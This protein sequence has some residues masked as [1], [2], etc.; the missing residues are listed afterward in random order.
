MRF[1]KDAVRPVDCCVLNL[2]PAKEPVVTREGYIF[3]R[4]AVIE[5]M[6]HEK[7]AIA[8]RVKQWKKRRDQLAN[9]KK[10]VEESE[11][12]AQMAKFAAAERHVVS[13]STA[14]S[15]KVTSNATVSA[16]ANSFWV[17]GV[18]KTAEMDSLKDLPPR[19]DETVR[20][21]VTNKPLKLKDLIPVKFKLAKRDGTET[22]ASNVQS[23]EN[24]SYVCAL[25]G[26]IL[27]NSQQLAVLL[28]SSAVVLQSAADQILKYDSKHSEKVM[29][30]IAN[31][32]L[33][34]IISLKRGGS[35]FTAAVGE[36]L[37]Q[38][39]ATLKKPA[40]AIN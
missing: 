2:Q 3:D 14:S 24:G 22:S 16:N 1:S 13:S 36:D 7:Q 11:K 4:S 20:C 38:I 19:P 25:T 37:T 8:L 27:T 5:Y 26:D 39:E 29:D 32:E 6:V 21:P 34:D 12:N 35:G 15:S 23:I 18:S 40:L 9:Q 30:P 28:P 33:E 17:P 10:Q 31:K